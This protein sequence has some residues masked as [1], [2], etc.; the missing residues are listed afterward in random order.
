VHE[1]VG[2]RRLDEWT[3]L[4]AGELIDA[5]SVATVFNHVSTSGPRTMAWLPPLPMALE[6]GAVPRKVP[7]KQSLVALELIEHTHRRRGKIGSGVVS[8]FDRLRRGKPAYADALISPPKNDRK[9][10][11][12]SSHRR[13]AWWRRG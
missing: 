13:G 6:S 2:V 11:S 12:S 8:V 4:S 9:K 1:E 7:F 5:L 10:I 3:L